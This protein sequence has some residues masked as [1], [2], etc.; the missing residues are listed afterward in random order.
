MRVRAARAARAAK[1]ARGLAEVRQVRG[2]WGRAAPIRGAAGPH[3][4][5]AVVPGAWSSMVAGVRALSA[6]AAAAAKR[7]VG[8]AVEWAGT[9]RAAPEATRRRGPAKKT[10]GSPATRRPTAVV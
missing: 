7:V 10:R 9:R 4:L 3:P 8:E 5:R 2:E 6:E 1:G